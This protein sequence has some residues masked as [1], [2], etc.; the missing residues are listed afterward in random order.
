MDKVAVFGSFVVDL[1]ARSPHLP[2]PG[3]TVKGSMFKMGPGGKGFNQCVAAKKAG[4]DVT[5]ITKVGNDSFANVLL[6]TMKELD[7]SQDYIFVNNSTETGIALITV[8]ESTSQNEIIIVPGACNTITAEEVASVESIISRSEY[9]LLQLEV[10]QDANEMVAE[11]ANKYNCKVVL[12]TAP[13]VPVT[14]DFL[15]KCYMVT[16]NEVEAEAVTGIK[17]TNFDSA[18]RAAKF[19]RNKGVIDIVITLGDR[20]VFVS[21]HGR[22]EII[23]AYKVNVVDTTGAGDAFNGGL[24]TSLAEGKNL[25]EA[26]RFANALAALSV[27]KM[28]T[29]PSMPSRKEIETFLSTAEQVN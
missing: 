13:Y 15:S 5:M 10:N 28:G 22:E 4:A 19:F 6:D 16:P 26:A 24:I 27:Q 18:K 20:G 17:V 9:V 25:L 21:T 3:E 23:P 2:V 1:M 29:T 11:L 7:M 12:N 8:D 14:D